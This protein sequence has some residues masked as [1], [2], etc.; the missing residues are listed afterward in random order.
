MSSLNPRITGVRNCIW[1]FHVG[2]QG[3]YL[4]CQA[5][6]ASTLAHRAIL[7]S[8]LCCPLW[9]RMKAITPTEGF[10]G[11]LYNGASYPTQ[12]HMRQLC[13]DVNPPS[14]GG[15]CTNW[16]GQTP[17][18][19]NC[20]ASNILFIRV[21]WK[22]ILSSMNILLWKRWE[23]LYKKKIARPGVICPNIRNPTSML[24]KSSVYFYS[25]FSHFLPVH[26]H[27][28]L[29]WVFLSSCCLFL[30]FFNQKKKKLS[31]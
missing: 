6:A 12:G 25:L 23:E 11:T 13:P 5:C 18:T 17:R 29:S 21:Y 30:V 19:V 4:D 26:C 10:C 28:L 7:L 14:T 31:S 24:L 3:P 2:F 15:N 9:Y 22:S 8:L 1:T 16:A 27:I 20:A